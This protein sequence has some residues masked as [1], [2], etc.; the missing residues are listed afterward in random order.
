MH[1]GGPAATFIEPTTE[2]D[3][4]AAIRAADES[5]TPLLVL[6]G[7]SNMLVGDDGF[8]GVVIKDARTGFTSVPDPADD[9][10]VLVTAVAGQ[11]WDELVAATV[12]NSWSGLEAMS[13]I[14][15]TVGAAP[16][17]N[18][19]AYGRDV[20]GV[21][22]SVRV[23]D[24]LLGE[25]RTLTGD[26]LGFGY[27]NSNLKRSM[28]ASATSDDPRAP[29]LPTPRYVVLDVTMKLGVDS[30][31]LPVK[32]PE[33]LDI[34]NIELGDRVPSVVVR[35]E[36]LKLRD[37]KGTLERPLHPGGAVDYDRWSA[38][39][40]FT[41]PLLTAEQSAALP[42]DAPRFPVAGNSALIETPAAWL[43]DTA[44]FPRGFGVHGATS[45]ATS[46]SKHPLVMTNRGNANAA[47]IVE[48]AR[49][50]RDG[51]KAKYNVELVPEPIFV[52]V[53]L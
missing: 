4:I 11:N 13:G 10:A 48:L 25:V 19:G 32:W 41:N 46:S 22:T 39:S 40:F 18:I 29:W 30:Q 28:L 9:A 6:G 26:E 51:V 21:I 17:Q 45:R 35:E 37:R 50:I 53:E 33:L 44:G 43:I 12:A 38:G 52:G 16:V 15:G 49:T 27:R 7:G 3:F 5:G 20:S 2:T 23:W 31:S 34:L 47:D 8:A 1:V 14:P 24:R 42:D 36:V